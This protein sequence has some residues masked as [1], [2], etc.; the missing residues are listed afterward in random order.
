MYDRF[1]P[2]FVFFVFV[3]LSV[4]CIFICS[5]TYLFSHYYSSCA[6]GTQH[7]G[8]LALTLLVACLCEIYFFV[9]LL[10]LLADGEMIYYYYF[11]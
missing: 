11:L 6:I 7:D 8:H 3:C 2:R 4:Y 10:V 9:V 5:L 1:P